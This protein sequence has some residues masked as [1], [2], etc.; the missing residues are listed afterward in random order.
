MFFS[1]LKA[2]HAKKMLFSSQKY[3]SHSFLFSIQ[4]KYIISQ[5]LYISLY[6]KPYSKMDTTILFFANLPFSSP[7]GIKSGIH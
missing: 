7:N 4:V 3:N 1:I 5:P 2:S 6:Y